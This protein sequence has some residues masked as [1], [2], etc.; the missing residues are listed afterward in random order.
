MRLSCCIITFTILEGLL[1]L[2]HLQGEP[3]PHE[4]DEG[5]LSAYSYTVLCNQRPLYKG[6]I[7]F[8]ALI[9]GCLHLYTKII[10]R[11]QS[12]KIDWLKKEAN[13]LA[14]ICKGKISD[15]HCFSFI[16][17]SNNTVTESYKLI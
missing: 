14:L 1:I 5:C 2:T 15:L 6:V 3:L 8:G 9:I 13:V 10:K 16:Y 17:G 7:A 4:H 12:N 11:P